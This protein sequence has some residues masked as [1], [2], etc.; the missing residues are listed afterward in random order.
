MS[1]KILIV[2]DDA[3]NRKLLSFILILKKMNQ[4][5]LVAGK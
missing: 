4:L 1:E 2:D 3:R 5:T